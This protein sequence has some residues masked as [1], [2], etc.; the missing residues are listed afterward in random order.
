M[1]ALST[2]FA[3]VV[4]LALLNKDI[5]QPAILPFIL[6]DKRKITLLDSPTQ[7]W[8]AQVPAKV[9][10]LIEA[11]NT[12]KLLLLSLG[13]VPR[14]Q[15]FGLLNIGFQARG[16]TEVIKNLLNKPNMDGFGSSKQKPAI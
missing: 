13:N 3:K 6:S 14:S 12:N 5:F 2:N 7:E 16:F 9:L 10:R 15:K 8:K 11:N 4:L 1:I